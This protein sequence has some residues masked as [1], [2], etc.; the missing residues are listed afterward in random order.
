MNYKRKKL[1]SFSANL[2]DKLE[3]G[4]TAQDLI[5]K[6]YRGEIITLAE[7]QFVCSVIRQLRDTDG[8][9]YTQIKDVDFCKNYRFRSTYMLFFK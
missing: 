1:Q 3:Y 8:K 9:I 5:N 4:S 6:A 2:P 7:E